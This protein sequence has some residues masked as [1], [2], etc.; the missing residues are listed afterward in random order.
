MDS[1]IGKRL[2]QYEILSKLG[3]GGMANVYK[4]R[5]TS[6]D[7]D[8]AVK[9]IRTDLTED[10]AFME[11]FAREARTIASL[12]HLHILKVFDYGQQDGIAYL[13]MEL[14]EGGSL[15]TLI[16]KTGALSLPVTARIL[17]QISGALDYAH[18]KGIVHRDL[19]SD[20]VLLD[21]AENAYLTDF[22][23]ARLLNDTSKMTQTGTIMGTPAYMAPELWTGKAADKQADIYA[24]GVILYEMLA[25]NTPF[26][27]DT[28]FVVMYQHLNEQP[29]VDDF[30]GDIP[31]AVETVI[32][33]AMAKKPEDRYPSAGELANTFDEA[34]GG[35]SQTKHGVVAKPKTDEVPVED[36]PPTQMLPR[37]NDPTEASKPT[38]VEK[39]PTQP[40]QT[41]TTP[42][43]SS[44]GLVWGVGIV[45]VIIVLAALLVVPRVQ[46]QQADASATAVAMAATQTQA[47]MPTATVTPSPTP[48][49]SPTPAP[50]DTPAATALAFDQL[51]F[52]TYTNKDLNIVFRYPKGWD[53]QVVKDQSIFVTED[54]KKLDFSDL[55]KGVIGA[56]YIQLNIGDAET[57]GALDM[58]SAQTAED[59]LVAFMGRDRI[60]NLDAVPGGR[61]PTATT[62]RTKSDLGVVRYIYS[63]IM[64]PNYFNIAMLQAPPD[65]AAAYN[66]A[67]MLPL[68][69]SI[70]TYSKEISTPIP[71][72]TATPVPTVFFATPSSFAT[73]D[74]PQIGVS[75]VY[76]KG[77][78]FIA[79]LQSG[80]ALP[81]ASSQAL[82]QFSNDDFNRPMNIFMKFDKNGFIA[83]KNPNDSIQV[84]F[85]DNYGSYTVNPTQLYDAPFPTVYARAGEQPVYGIAVAGWVALVKVRD[86]LYVSIFAHAG[87]GK[88]DAFLEGVLLPMLRGMKA[89]EIRTATPSGLQSSGSLIS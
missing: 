40:P 89:T 86:D 73:Q 56:P 24:L 77:W 87:R 81:T 75:F 1:L 71:A 18:Y 9:V 57:L 2:G 66:T 83:V 52:D 44:N 23:I 35:I 62:T 29:P 48:T 68:I 47:A 80:A 33:K 85:N 84:I 32:L 16:Q 61:L 36:G 5:Q 15:N 72:V 37:P 6:V 78:V 3:S 8:V 53:V 88:E 19:K 55:N 50:T 38:V 10:A 60:T 64:G 26:S 51:Q 63:V 82:D 41:I 74:D 22:G 70:D 28:P 34:I 59:A 25:G 69:R 21:S 20:N 46:Q 79:N 58:K 67:I 76:P 4:A 17:K 27:G 49:V 30:K 12:S 31:S 45:A 65:M 54:F 13:V 11:R 43:K 7:R 14:L 39:L 42:K